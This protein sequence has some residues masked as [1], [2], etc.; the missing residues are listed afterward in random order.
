MVMTDKELID[1]FIEEDPLRPGPDRAR[2][3]DY[4]VSIW[5][6]IAY[7]QA[8]RGDVDLVASDYELP[9]EAVEAARAF[10]DRH[11]TAIDARIA[12]HDAAFT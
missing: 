12:E 1:R 10:Y 8:A 2:L 11:R 7:L 5:A 3:R 4:G 9:R 6:L